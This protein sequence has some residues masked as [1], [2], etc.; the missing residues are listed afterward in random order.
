MTT[1]TVQ[2]SSSGQ[3]FIVRS[4]GANIPKDPANSDYCR[5]IADVTQSVADQSETIAIA[6]AKAEAQ[7][8][9]DTE[10]KAKVAFAT[11]L[12]DTNAKLMA[13]GLTASDISTLLNASKA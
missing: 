2:V 7:A 11:Q 5:Y 1:Y 6:T 10:A 4:D 8:L 3:I 12:A 13:L 9:V